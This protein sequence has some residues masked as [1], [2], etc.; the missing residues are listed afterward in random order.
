M[1]WPMK[2]SARRCTR[3]LWWL[4]PALIQAKGAYSKMG[5]TKRPFVYRQSVAAVEESTSVEAKLTVGKEVVA[6]KMIYYLLVD[7]LLH[8]LGSDTQ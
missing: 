3:C 2:P 7:D 6:F 8:Y 5:C 1:P 4:G